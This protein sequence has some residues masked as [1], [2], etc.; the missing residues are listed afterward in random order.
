MG[1]LYKNEIELTESVALELYEAADKY[2]QNDLLKLCEEFLCK[3]LRLDNFTSMIDFVE[4]FEM[5]FLRDSIYEFI[6]HNLQ[7]IKEKQTEYKVPDAY[8]WEVLSRIS[9]RSLKR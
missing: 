5:Q 2:M 7:E 6:I 1:F 3:N 9:Q 8:L 4:K